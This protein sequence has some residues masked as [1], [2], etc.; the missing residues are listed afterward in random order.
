ME[1][2]TTPYIKERYIDILPELSSSAQKG[3]IAYPLLSCPR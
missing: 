1:E 3:P 2:L